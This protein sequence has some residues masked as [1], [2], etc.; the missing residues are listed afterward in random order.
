VGAVEDEDAGNPSPMVAAIAATTTSSP[1]TRSLRIRIRR[2]GV[3]AGWLEITP[4][5][6]AAGCCQHVSDFRYAGDMREP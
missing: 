1:A 4:P 2:V 3:R 6:K 5:L